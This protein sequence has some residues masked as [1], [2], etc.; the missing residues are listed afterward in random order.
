MRTLVVLAAFFA[1]VQPVTAQ[2]KAAP[3][4]W[5]YAELVYRDTSGR[6]KD[7]NQALTMTIRWTSGAGEFSVNGWEE[8]AGKLKTKFKKEETASSQKVQ[9]LNSLGAEG[10]EL[11][12]QNVGTTMATT[13]MFKRRLP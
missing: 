12:S 8:L 1:L 7:G 5:E 6:G 3:V 4:K 11:V 13:L 2:E 10:W 9:M